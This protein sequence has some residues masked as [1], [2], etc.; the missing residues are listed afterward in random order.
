MTTRTE[1]LQYLSALDPTELHALQRDLYRASDIHHQAVD[2][3]PEPPDPREAIARAFFG[4][5]EGYDQR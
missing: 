3:H 4:G 2:H 5:G 1:V